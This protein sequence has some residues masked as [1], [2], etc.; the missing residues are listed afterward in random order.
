ML[1]RNLLKIGMNF[2]LNLKYINTG[3]RSVS[4]TISQVG[5][6]SNMKEVIVQVLYLYFFI[7]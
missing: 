2:I 4:Q 3:F 7:L 1:R 5:F 6:K